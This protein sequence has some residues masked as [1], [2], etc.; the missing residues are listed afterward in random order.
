MHEVGRSK[1]PVADKSE[2]SMSAVTVAVKSPAAGTVSKR[3]AGKGKERSS[4]VTASKRAASNTFQKSRS[5][6]G[7]RPSAKTQEA[8]VVYGVI[9]DL[10]VVPMPGL[11][12]LATGGKYVLVLV[13][14]NLRS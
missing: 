8:E 1:R 4:A 10:M 9:L 3:P 11:S 2:R 12:N 13:I 6:L 5:T 7:K 14:D